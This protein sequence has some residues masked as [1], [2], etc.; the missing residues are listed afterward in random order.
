MSESIILSFF[1]LL[2]AIILYFQVVPVFNYL[3]DAKLNFIDEF[4]WINICIALLFMGVIGIISGIIPAIKIARFDPID[5][6][7]GKIRMKEK[8]IYSRIM[9]S[10]Q[11][12][13][14]ITLITSAFFI[15]KQT[16]FL[17]NHQLGFEQENMLCFESEIPREKQRV[18]QEILKKIPGVE[19]VCLSAGTPP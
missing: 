18:L 6:M 3:L 2:L 9:V 17:R 1:S 16:N 4:T 19:D 10:F 8:S 7:K 14:I 15:N 13:I 5:V 11:Y 12:L